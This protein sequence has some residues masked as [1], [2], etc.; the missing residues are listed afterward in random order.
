M[1][2]LKA[3]CVVLCF[4]SFSG[5]WIAAMSYGELI[6]SLRVAYILVIIFFLLT[7]IFYLAYQILKDHEKNAH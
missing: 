6:T 3:I 1:K 4:L 7:V 5:I 2:A